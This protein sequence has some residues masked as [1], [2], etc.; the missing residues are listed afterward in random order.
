MINSKLEGESNSLPVYLTLLDTSVS[1]VF[2]PRKSLAYHIMMHC[3]FCLMLSAIGRTMIPQ[4]FSS[5][6]EGGAT[7]M[8]YTFTYPRQYMSHSGPTLECD[9]VLTTT[10]YL[11]PSY[12]RVGANLAVYVSL[13]YTGVIY[14][15]CYLQSYTMLMTYYQFSHLCWSL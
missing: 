5:I 2:W 6:F 10:Q 9:N 14:R 12:A 8:Y 13:L 4:Y 3:A 1:A 15:C 11:Q 7:E